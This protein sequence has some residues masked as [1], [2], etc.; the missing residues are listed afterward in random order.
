MSLCAVGLPGCFEAPPE[1]SVPERIPPLL[2]E[3]SAQPPIRVLYEVNSASVDMTI[4]F[5]V[6]PSEEDVQALF[7][8]DVGS[9]NDVVLCL[10]NATPADTQFLCKNG[11]TNVDPGCHTI[12]VR[13]SYVNNF[14]GFEIDDPSLG[15]ETT[16]FANLYNPTDPN[17]PP[18][19]DCFPQGPL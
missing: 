18:P 13:A 19:V 16:W 5:R 4:P 9:D 2:D 12:T 15:T 10:D 8:I 17:A 1:Y 11:W 6:S 3:A 7:I 14:D